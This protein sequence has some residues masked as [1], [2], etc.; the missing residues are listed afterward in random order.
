MRGAGVLSILSLLALLLAGCSGSKG[1]DE[2][3]G[4]A[5]PDQ[6]REATTVY[7]SIPAPDW[8]VGQWWEWEVT[9]GSQTMEG[10]FCSIVVDTAGSSYRLATE[11]T[12]WAKDEAAFDHPLL[13]MVSKGDL[14]EDGPDGAYSLLS[15]PL[16]DGKTWTASMPNIAWGIVDAER[17]DIAMTAGFLTPTHGEPPR[18]LLTGK[19]GE[20]TVLQ[21]EYDPSTGWFAGLRF[22]DVDPGEEGLEVGYRAKSSGLNYTGPYFQHTARPLIAFEDL[23]GF[24]DVPTEGGQPYTGAPQPYWPFTMGSGTTLYGFVVIDS[25]V[26]ARTLV[27]VDPNHGQ[28]NLVSHGSL[29]DDEQELFFDEPGIAGD[30][31][32]VTG[33]AGGFTAAVGQLV[34]VT[35]GA[36]T[37]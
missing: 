10:T 13:G 2:G 15:F 11:D 33:G 29:D 27:L 20:A 17:A 32:V 28:R 12:A 1:S 9:L 22:F 8:Q 21:A 19:I 3:A 18:V 36:F 35:E 31:K 7:A 6:G 5:D 16:T 37:L 14:A 34:E 4:D 24:N 30:W 26:G 25:V 23:N